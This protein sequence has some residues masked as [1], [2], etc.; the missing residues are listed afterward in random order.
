V[1]LKIWGFL[2]EEVLGQSL[3]GEFRQ[4]VNLF[5]EIP[6]DP[7]DEKFV[8]PFMESVFVLQERYGG[9]FLRPEMGD[10][11]FTLL[12]FW[13]APT[14]HE[15]DIDRALNFL[16]DLRERTRLKFRAGVTYRM[17]YAGFMG[18]DLREEYTA[19]G[20]GVNLA[21]RM[22]KGAESGEVW[23][24]EEIWRRA[25]RHF[26]TREIGELPFK[27]FTNRL[28]VFV[29][30]GR[31]GFTETAYKGEF[32]GRE[33]ESRRLLEFLEPL[34][35]GEFAGLVLI[36]G[37]AGIGKSRLVHSVRGS[38]FSATPAMGGMPGR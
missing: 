29:L 24:D 28:K 27:G 38:N 35:R 2:P 37:E 34:T 20:M 13:G 26:S 8:A 11:G 23:L 14:S 1:S 6:V 22:M 12:I 31:K 25:Q 18:A 30:E 9:F 16:L 19:Y 10:K 5:I 3:K 32:V 21:S 4:V 7:T 17:A 15:N 33:Q 36:K